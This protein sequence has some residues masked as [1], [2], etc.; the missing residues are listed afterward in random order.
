MI[1]RQ[2]QLAV[3]HDVNFELRIS[4]DHVAPTHTQVKQDRGICI[5]GLSKTD[6]NGSSQLGLSH[7]CR[8]SH[9]VGSKEWTLHRSCFHVRLVL[10]NRPS[11]SGNH[12][13]VSIIACRSRGLSLPNPLKMSQL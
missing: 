10:C 5:Q 7:P 4:D 1:L 12:P 8:L 3:V 6:L 2:S 11:E 9:S 13:T